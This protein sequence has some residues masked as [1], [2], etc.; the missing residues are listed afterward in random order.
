MKRKNAQVLIITALC[1]AFSIWG[2]A[3]LVR[4][5]DT[6]DIL[7]QVA[8]AV[9]QLEKGP[10]GIGNVEQFVSALK[11]VDPGHAPE[12]VKQALRSYIA[13]CEQDLA[14]LRAGRNTSQVDDKMAQAREI[15]V[16]TVRKNE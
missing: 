10:A 12:E 8:A 13:A 1:G 11:R 16:Q 15:L 5:R 2:L 14:E 9:L 4:Q 6:R 3:T 7:G